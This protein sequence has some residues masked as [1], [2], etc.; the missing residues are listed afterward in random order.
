MEDYI[1]EHGIDV[2]KEQIAL[3][4]A[5]AHAEMVDMDKEGVHHLLDPYQVTHYHWEVFKKYNI[6][7]Y[8]FGGSVRVNPFSDDS[9]V[10]PTDLLAFLWCSGCDEDPYEWW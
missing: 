6:P 1:K 10:H 3:E 2:T 4:L 9:P 8:I 7:H 5:N